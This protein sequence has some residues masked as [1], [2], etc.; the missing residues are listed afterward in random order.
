MDLLGL[1]GELTIAD[2]IYL[3][4]FVSL[5]SVGLDLRAIGMEIIVQY[6]RKSFTDG[7]NTLFKSKV[8]DELVK[9]QCI[10]NGFENLYLLEDN[11]A[12]PKL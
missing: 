8:L 11:Q 2:F 7:K 6:V 1:E 3:T 12:T 9:Q 5:G 10:S 4:N